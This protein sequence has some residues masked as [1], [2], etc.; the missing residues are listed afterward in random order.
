MYLRFFYADSSNEI[1]NQNRLALLLFY[2]MAVWNLV[3]GGLIKEL[4]SRFLFYL[5]LLPQRVIYTL[6]IQCDST[7]D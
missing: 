4:K 3:T 6:S 7:S 1:N 5:F 2:D